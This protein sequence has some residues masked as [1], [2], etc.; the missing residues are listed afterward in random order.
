MRCGAGCCSGWCSVGG[1]LGCGL[2][3]YCGACRRENNSDRAIRQSQIHQV[4]L[5]RHVLER[6][7]ISA[8]FLG[9]LE[10]LLTGQQGREQ[11]GSWRQV[12]HDYGFMWCMCAFTHCA[13]SVE[14]G[15]AECGGKVAVGCA[16][17]R[18]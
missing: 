15:H 10:M 14:C 1:G 9:S 3:K 16:A 5:S 18:G 13:E 2:R 7:F 4:K 17:G 8:D 11:R 6:E 12:L